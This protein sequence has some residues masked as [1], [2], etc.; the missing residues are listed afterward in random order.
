MPTEKTPFSPHSINSPFP[1]YDP[2]PPNEKQDSPPNLLLRQHKITVTC[3]ECHAR[4]PMSHP[5]LQSAPGMT[6][7][8]PLSSS[9]RELRRS[10]RETQ[11]THNKDPL[12]SLILS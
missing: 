7:I 5:V 9:M 10:S 3:R 4:N 6:T 2:S 1:I 11:S 12:L 8:S